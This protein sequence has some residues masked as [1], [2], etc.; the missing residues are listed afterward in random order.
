MRRLPPP[1][2]EGSKKREESEIPGGRGEGRRWRRGTVFRGDEEAGGRTKTTTTTPVGWGLP[3][4]WLEDWRTD[5]SPCGD[6]SVTAA[7]T[8]SLVHPSSPS[9]RR[10]RKE[11]EVYE[12]TLHFEK[13]SSASA[14]LLVLRRR[15]S[16]RPI[17]WMTFLTFLSILS[18]A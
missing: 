7:T 5:S 15:I 12:K 14:S 1:A 16:S 11:E 17:K 13:N 4:R 10:L 9:L 18:C 8:K 6:V 2:A 3:P